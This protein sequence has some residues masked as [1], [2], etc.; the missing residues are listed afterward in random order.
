MSVIS[1]FSVPTFTIC[2]FSAETIKEYTLKPGVYFLSTVL[3]CLSYLIASKNVLA[4]FFMTSPLV[5]LIIV[6]G[7]KWEVIEAAMAGYI[8]LLVPLIVAVAIVVARMVGVIWAVFLALTELILALLIGLG[9]AV[10]LAKTSIIAKTSFSFLVITIG[11]MIIA[12]IFLTIY[13]YMRS[14]SDTSELPLILKIK[15]FIANLLGNNSPVQTLTSNKQLKFRGLEFAFARQITKFIAFFFGTK[16]H[17]AILTDADFSCANLEHTDLSTDKLT[18][19][20]FYRAKNL[21]L[22]RVGKN[23]LNDPIIRD[24][25]VNETK[26]NK[27]FVGLNLQGV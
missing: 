10:I 1:L 2:Y 23:I 18:R 25:V 22:A 6:A 15:T 16:F 17:N 5:M 7:E 9:T 13:I 8:V 4:T 26:N 3:Y 24:L 14:R 27:S 11:I 19:T 21:H 20:R 12:I